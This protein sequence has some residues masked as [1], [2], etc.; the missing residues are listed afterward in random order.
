MASN[1]FTRPK[2]LHPTPS[3]CFPPGPPAGVGVFT[4]T[5]TPV[6]TS[7]ASPGQITWAVAAENSFYQ[8]GVPFTVVWNVPNATNG[9]LFPVTNKDFIGH[10]C[11]ITGPPGT[12]FCTIKVTCPNG[13]TRTKPFS[14]I[15]TP[16]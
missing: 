11:D 8:L 9:P 6:L 1:Y 3:A 2:G 12:Y 13:Q 15:I 7:I 16:L 5:I 10:P 14:Y 4:L